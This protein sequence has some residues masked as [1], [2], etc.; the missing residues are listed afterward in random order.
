LFE[1]GFSFYLEGLDT[2]LL[3]FE[4]SVF[5]LTVNLEFR[6]IFPAVDADLIVLLKDESSLSG[7]L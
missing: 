2:I 4:F 5:S 3:A 6:R 7:A 1:D